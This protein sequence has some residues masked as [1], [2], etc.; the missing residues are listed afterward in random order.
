[1]PGVG[2]LT[3]AL[4]RPLGI[5]LA[6]PT[7]PAGTPTLPL[8][9]TMR[10][11]YRQRFLLLTGLVF[12]GLAASVF[13][14][15]RHGPAASWLPATAL[16]SGVSSDIYVGLW[17]GAGA[18]MLALGWWP[19]AARWL[20]AFAAACSAAW[21]GAAVIHAV[22]FSRPGDWSTAVALV[23]YAAAILLIASWPEPS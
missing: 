19:P 4:I 17:G 5:A 13:Y 11:G 15:A 1:V 3:R 6:R 2:F 16:V 22:R 23:S 8:E 14:D 18:L 9:A 7:C 12:A 20:F 21:A 10:L